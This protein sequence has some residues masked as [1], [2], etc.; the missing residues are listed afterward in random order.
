[1]YTHVLGSTQLS[2]R[3]LQNCPIK[4][5]SYIYS[6][7]QSGRGQWKFTCNVP[8]YQ[9]SQVDTRVKYLGMWSEAEYK[10]FILVCRLVICTG[11]EMDLLSQR[12]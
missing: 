9:G 3:E 7:D 12:K 8:A 6:Q 5:G 11:P 1:M 4:P 10:V 2:D